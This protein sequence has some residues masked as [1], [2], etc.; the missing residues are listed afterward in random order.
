MET[1]SPHVAWGLFTVL[2]VLLLTWEKVALVTL[3]LRP[4]LGIPVPLGEA[5][6]GPGPG[7]HSGGW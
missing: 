7:N 4:V 1:K 2:H 6:Q 3:L 5:F